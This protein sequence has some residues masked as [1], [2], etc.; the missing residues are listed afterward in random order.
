MKTEDEGDFGV[1]LQT[2]FAQELAVVLFQQQR[3]SQKE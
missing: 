2:S 1:V 3:E